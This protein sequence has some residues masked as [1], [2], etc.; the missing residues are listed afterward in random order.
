MSALDD[1]RANVAALEK[2]QELVEVMEAAAA[3]H[4]A[5]PSDAN[6]AAHNRAQEAL[7]AHWTATR[8]AGRGATVG[9]DAVRTES[10]DAETVN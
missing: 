6:Y 1:A 10:S 7:D 8:P 3:A 5:D 9:G 2:E 4:V